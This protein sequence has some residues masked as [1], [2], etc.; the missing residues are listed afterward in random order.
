[1]GE[2]RRKCTD[3]VFYVIFI[4]F[5]V[6]MFIVAIFG[7]AKG[8]PKKLLAPVDNDGKFCGV[9]SGYEDYDVLYFPDISSTSNIKNKYV[10]VKG[11]CPSATS[12]ASIDCKTT[13]QVTDC[14]AYTR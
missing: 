1:L 12:P 10:C 14:N 11:G 5:C 13:T 9:D 2:D 4:V 3:I 7:W 8:D 6:G